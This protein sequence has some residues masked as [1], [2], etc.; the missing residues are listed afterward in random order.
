MK[1][2]VVKCH[3]ERIRIGLNEGKPQGGHQEA[4]GLEWHLKW[5]LEDKFMANACD[6]RPLSSFHGC[7]LL[8]LS[9]RIIIIRYLLESGIELNALHTPPRVI[10]R[11][12][13]GWTLLSSCFTA[14]EIEALNVS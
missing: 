4:T 13:A 10:I 12:T 7:N 8:F 2:N 9:R 5:S 6:S 14:E 3:K 1:K 11:T